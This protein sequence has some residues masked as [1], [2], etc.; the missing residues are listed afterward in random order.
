MN[1]IKTVLTEFSI[2]ILFALVFFTIWFKA[3]KQI[4]LHKKRNYVFILALIF[5][6]YGVA[7]IFGGSG[8]VAALFFS[9]LLGNVHPIMKALN[10]K[11]KLYRKEHIQ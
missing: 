9:L 10:L 2:G 4:P 6:Q 7:E 11:E 3:V 8:V 1:L 5:I